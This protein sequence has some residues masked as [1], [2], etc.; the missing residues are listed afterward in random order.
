LLAF[1][2]ASAD[3]SQGEGK[4]MLFKLDL[5]AACHQ[6][7]ESHEISTAP[8]LQ[9]FQSHSSVGAGFKLTESFAVIFVIPCPLDYIFKRLFFLF[10][11]PLSN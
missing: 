3:S 10:F 6:F 5:V 11:D 1:S 9:M 4:K 2:D 8:T 7:Y